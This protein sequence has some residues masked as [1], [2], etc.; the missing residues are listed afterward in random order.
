MAPQRN[1]PHD[2]VIVPA[3]D[4]T[5]SWNA[6]PVPAV[7]FIAPRPSAY[8]DDAWL[9]NE[10]RTANRSADS[11]SSLSKAPLPVPASN[12]EPDTRSKSRKRRDRKKKTRAAYKALRESGH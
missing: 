12:E 10:P 5:N 2:D 7:S 11:E 3:T 8:E 9:Y 1:T 4:V 6:H